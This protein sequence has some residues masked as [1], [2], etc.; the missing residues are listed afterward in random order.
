MSLPPFDIEN[1]LANYH[2]AKG[3]KGAKVEAPYPERTGASHE[4]GALAALAILARGKRENENADADE[5]AAIMETDG[6]L[7]RDW[8]DALTHILARRPQG[9]SKT[10]WPIFCDAVLRFAD[11]YGATL[12]DLGWT[13]DDVFRAPAHWGRTDQRGAAWFARGGRVIRADAASIT[14]EREGVRSTLP[15]RAAEL[16]C[17]HPAIRRAE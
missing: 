13:F 1:E 6:G 2:A 10:E 8:A 4:H 12:A 15:R 9:C 7:P 14:L 3:A 17:M 16:T 11:R 5:R